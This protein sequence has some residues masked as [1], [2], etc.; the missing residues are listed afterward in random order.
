VLTIGG[1]RRT[2]PYA[3]SRRLSE[4]REEKYFEFDFD[5]QPVRALPGETVGAAL[6][7]SG[8]RGLRVAEDGSWRGMVCGIGV[9]WECRCVIDGI[10][11][12]R[13]CMTL[14]QPDMQVSRQ[15]GAGN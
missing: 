10:A 9:C 1:G 5:G 8:L 3:Q 4:G 14:A 6:L 11:N 15:R 7:A 2:V 13:A 12:T